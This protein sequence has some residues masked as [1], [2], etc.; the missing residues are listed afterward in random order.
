MS[1]RFDIT[2]ENRLIAIGTHFWCSGHLS[3][4]MVSEKSVDS[5]YCKKCHDFLT[6]EARVLRETGYNKRSA[7]M[8]KAGT[9]GLPIGDKASSPTGGAVTIQFKVSGDVSK[10][11]ETKCPIVTTRKN[12]KV[13]PELTDKILSLSRLGLD[14]RA[15]ALSINDAVSYRTVSRILKEVT[16]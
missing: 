1:E 15:V 8:P 11:D 3:A 9:P 7:W 12:Y 10:T 16:A 6:E 5:R 13:T 14:S 4:V 2:E